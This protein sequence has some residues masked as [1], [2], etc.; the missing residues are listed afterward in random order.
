MR[1]KSRRWDKMGTF[2]QLAEIMTVETGA[3]RKGHRLFSI[4]ALGLIVVAIVQI[5]GHLSPPPEE[6][7]TTGLYAAMEAYL[8]DF[9]LGKPSMLDMYASLSLAMPIMLLWMAIINL[10]VARYSGTRDKL[11]RKVCSLN[12]FAVAALIWVNV[13][14]K[15]SPTAIA[16]GIVGV[17]FFIARY[18]MRHGRMPR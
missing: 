3:F 8:F 4:A 9:G 11:F 18:R 15:V 5:V 12:I 10:G 6:L 7:V 13:Y 1:Q 17:L 16:L 2:I 14:Y